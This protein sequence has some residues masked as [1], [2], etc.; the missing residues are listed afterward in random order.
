MRQTFLLLFFFSTVSLLAQHPKV[1]VGAKDQMASAS[2]AT[3]SSELFAEYLGVSNLESVDKKWLPFLS[4][5]ISKN[6]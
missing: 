3:K 4:T 2:A 6:K 5:V 1:Q